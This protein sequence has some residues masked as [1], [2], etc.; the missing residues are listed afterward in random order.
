MGGD[1]SSLFISQTYYH[2]INDFEY[3]YAKLQDTSFASKW[4]VYTL[5]MRN[6]S[7]SGTWNPI[8]YLDQRVYIQKTCTIL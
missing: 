2:Y 6:I 4:F 3:Y 5:H 8:A 7:H 1:R